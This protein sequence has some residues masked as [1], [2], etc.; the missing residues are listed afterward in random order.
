M[1]DPVLIEI[2]EDTWVK[3]N[4]SGITTASVWKN[5]ITQTDQGCVI[6]YYTTRDTGNPAPTTL[7]GAVRW[8]GG[9]LAFSDST[10]SDLYIRCGNGSGEARV[11]L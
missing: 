10:S 8:T 5:S 3:V 4:T 11:K 1:A 9:Q 2:P 6:W 7:E